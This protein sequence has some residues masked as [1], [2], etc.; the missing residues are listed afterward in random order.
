MT[1]RYSEFEKTGKVVIPEAN[2]IADSVESIVAAAENAVSGDVIGIKAGKYDMSGT[3]VRIKQKDNVVL[4]SIDGE[5][6]FEGSGFHKKDGYHKTVIDNL[7]TITDNSKNIMVHGITF[8]NS[9]CHG[10]K[11]EGEANVGDIVIDSCNFKNICERMIK[12]SKGDKGYRVPRVVISNCTFEDSELPYD[13]DHTEEFAGDYIAGIDMMVLDGAIISG[14]TFRNIKGKYGGGRGAVFLW[15]E[16][17]NL[18]AENNVIE[19]CD[20]GICFGN[21]HNVNGIAHVDGGVIKDNTI[22]NIT[23]HAIE[24]AWTNNIEIR[25]NKSDKESADTTPKK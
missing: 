6:I 20:R 1:C 11:V 14:N 15:V 17:K 10:I 12:G 5:V 3:K 18:T 22:R 19:N 25:D 16:S 21:P 24:L 4:R 7:L 9:N 23:S 13:T 8:M 2:I